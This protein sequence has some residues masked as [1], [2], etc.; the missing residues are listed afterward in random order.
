MPKRSAVMSLPHEVKNWLDSAL[1]ENGF[2]N[3]RLLADELSARGY[4]ISKS[5][6]HRYGQQF[7]EKLASLRLASEQARAIVEAAP[8]EDNAINDALM[9][10]VQ[11]KLFKVIQDVE[12]DPQKVNLASLA[13][14][15]A[16]LGRAS[17][18]QKKYA[19]EVR[20]K[21]RERAAQLAGEMAQAQGMGE[22]QV[23]FWREKFLGVRK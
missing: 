3:Y 23:R 20:A 2:A 14:S 10:L 15:I 17:V 12:V 18:T 8:D 11:D 4:E 21:E 16:E 7:E 5:A 13:K 1:A 22:E 6:I 19:E 9:R